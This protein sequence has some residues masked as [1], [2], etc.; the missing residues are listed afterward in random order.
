[1]PY[2]IQVTDAEIIRFVHDYKAE[3]DFAP[4]VRDIAKE[5][6]VAPSSI[7]KR[8]ADLVEQG[9]LVRPGGLPRALLVTPVGMKMLTERL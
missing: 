9:A 3:H 8:L 6:S 5:F 4:S 2:P 1:M 7:Q